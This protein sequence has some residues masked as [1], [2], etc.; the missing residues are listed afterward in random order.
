VTFKAVIE[1][2]AFNGGLDRMV[3]GEFSI[4]NLQLELPMAFRQYSPQQS[5]LE[6]VIPAESRFG[7]CIVEYPLAFSIADS[8]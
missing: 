8:I 2:D 1:L 7:G 6:F 5:G 4:D 3:A